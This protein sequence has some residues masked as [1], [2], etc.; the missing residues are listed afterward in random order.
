VAI[1]PKEPDN[2]T[3]APPSFPT[4]GGGGGNVPPPTPATRCSVSSNGLFGADVGIAQEFTFTYQTIVIPSVTVA[5]LNIDML[6]SLEDLMGN[7]IISRTFPQC[8]ND[9][10]VQESLAKSVASPPPQQLS[11]S[12]NYNYNSNN[13]KQRGLQGSGTSSLDGFS[14]RPRDTVVEGGTSNNICYMY[15]DRSFVL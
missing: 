14:I 10:G 13:R 5:E 11:S 12:S 6:K 9:P 3:S 1:P 7:E 2:P 15:L 4:T 8:S